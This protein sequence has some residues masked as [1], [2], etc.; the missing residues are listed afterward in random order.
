[1][2]F[3]ICGG[4]PLCG[5]IK[6]EGAKNAA[7]PM[8]F[9]TLLTREPVTLYGLPEILDVEIALSLL[10][11]MGAS[12]KRGADGGVTLSTEKAKA[13]D[14]S[15]FRVRELRA[16]AYLLGASLARFGG[17]AIPHTGGC[18]L[19]CRPLDYHRAA[20]R[21]LG[22]TWEEDETGI[23]VWGERLCGT[24][25]ALPYPSVG[26][27]V[28]FI[29]AALGAEGESTLFGFAGEHHV[30][31]F[32]AFL[33]TLG[34][35]IR[36]E[37]QCLRVEGGARLHGGCYTVAPDAIEAGTYL[38]AAAATGGEVTV[39]RVRYAELSPLLLAFGRMNVPFRFCGDAVTVYPVKHPVGTAVT[40]APYPS[41]P[42]DLHPPMTVLL[43]LAS[44]GGTMCDLVFSD[45]FAYAEELKKMG[46]RIQRAPRGLRILES[47]LRGACVSAPDLRGG[48]ALLVAALA[49][50]G[51]SRL[52]GEQYLARG[53]AHL[54]TKLFSL[55]A[56]V[57]VVQ[58][59]VAASVLASPE[60]HTAECTAK[61]GE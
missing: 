49:A 4:R 14:A 24:S 18:A 12:V 40:A 36:I 29:L 41:F 28:N 23:T 57:K 1:M 32:I 5:R 59:S 38:I 19:G 42:T 16:S 37:G 25:F 11:D 27:T 10:C 50:E 61:E 47:R 26:A 51:E 2:A 13:P 8:I 39:E 6:A 9:A 48:A 56:D 22:A 55:G 17:G 58:D 52:S 30:L 60:T 15:L 53:Y 43:A 45:R 44:G 33:R 54:L 34:A 35:R 46:A 3:L 7:L 20:F 21:A 31:D